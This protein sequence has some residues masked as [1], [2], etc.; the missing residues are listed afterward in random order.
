MN[1]KP[2]AGT[3]SKR[4]RKK[5]KQKKDTP[6]AKETAYPFRFPYSAYREPAATYRPS[7]DGSGVLLNGKNLFPA[8]E[9]ALLAHAMGLDHLVAVGIGTLH[10]TGCRQLAVGRS[11]GISASLGYFT[12]WYCHFDT[13]SWALPEQNS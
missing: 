6:S 12:L 4:E 13:S 8:I 11:S 5:R 10:K 7:S 9:A 3:E 1:G 2:L